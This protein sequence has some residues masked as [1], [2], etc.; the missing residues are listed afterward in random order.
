MKKGLWLILLAF[1]AAPVWAAG[2]LEAPLPEGGQIVKQTDRQMAVAYPLSHDQALE[3]YKNAL[4]GQEDIKFRDWK[5][6]TYIE[7]NGR[8]PWHSITIAKEDQK[9]TT[10]TV[11]ADSWTWILGTLI[12]RFIGVFV[13]LVVLMIA[14]LIATKIISWSVKKRPPATAEKA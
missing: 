12:L 9:G 2:F 7:D 5:N 3:F 13:V 8:R 14:L 6:E 10:I 1:T 11:S 4:S